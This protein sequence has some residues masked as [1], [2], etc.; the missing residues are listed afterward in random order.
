MALKGITNKKKT[1]IG[2]G[3]VKMSSMNKSKKRSY[4][5]NRGQG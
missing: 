5:K 1:S 3:N 4:K 2:K